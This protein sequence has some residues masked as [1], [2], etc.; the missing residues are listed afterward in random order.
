MTKSK[1]DFDCV[2]MKWNIQK[3]LADEA[4]ELTDEQARAYY[5]EKISRHPVLSEFLSR[6]AGY[7][8]KKA[9]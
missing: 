7:Q 5:R 8:I 3:Q 9:A 2:E 1:K 4:R 6:V